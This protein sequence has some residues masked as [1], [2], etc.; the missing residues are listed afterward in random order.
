MYFHHMYVYIN[1]YI[2]I[3]IFVIYITYEFIFFQHD[4][5]YRLGA[6]AVIKANF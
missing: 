1:M 6:E 3:C 4:L 5:E 2:H